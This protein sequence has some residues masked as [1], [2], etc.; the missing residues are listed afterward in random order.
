MGNLIV[1]N[2]KLRL[3]KTNQEVMINPGQY[4]AFSKQKEI[5]DRFVPHWSQ[6]GF[7]FSFKEMGVRERTNEYPQERLAQDAR[8]YTGQEVPKYQRINYQENYFYIDLARADLGSAYQLTWQPKSKNAPAT[9]VSIAND[10]GVF[11]ADILHEV[12]HA[13][14]LAHE[15]QRADRHLYVEPIDEIQY[16]KDLQEGQQIGRQTVNESVPFG[17]YDPHSIMHYPAVFKLKQNGQYIGGS[18]DAR[19]FPQRLSEGDLYTA[20]FLYNESRILECLEKMNSSLAL[21]YGDKDRREDPERECQVARQ[22]FLLS[23]NGSVIERTFSV[24]RNQYIQLLNL[25]LNIAAQDIALYQW[26]KSNNDMERQLQQQR[27]SVATNRNLLLSTRNRQGSEVDEQSENN[28]KRC[29]V[30]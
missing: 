7:S 20:R 8:F 18:G 30:M 21:Q 16:Q 27:V 3:Q 26:A 11:Q 22:L 5:F 29:I 9:Y 17:P 19:Q 1:A 23:I 28:K 14:G 12:G 13:L 6:A 2:G 10:R 4:E 24:V 15:H 25:G